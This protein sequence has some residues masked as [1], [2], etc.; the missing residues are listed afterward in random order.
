VTLSHPLSRAC[1]ALRNTSWRIAGQDNQPDQREPEV[2]IGAVHRASN[3]IKWMRYDGASGALSLLDLDQPLAC[4]S[5]TFGRARISNARVF[6]K[7]RSGGIHG[8]L[9]RVLRWSPCK[10]SPRGSSRSINTT[11]SISVPAG[12]NPSQPRPA[13]LGLCVVSGDAVSKINWAG[14]GAERLE[15]FAGGASS[16]RPDF[17]ATAS[18]PY[19]PATA[20]AA[21]PETPR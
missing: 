5:E 14:D 16:A 10:L 20:W 9:L 18:F 4:L 19:R 17:S 3:P 7:G 1:C 6:A 21:A 2:Q 11:K 12:A 8:L 15:A 13:I